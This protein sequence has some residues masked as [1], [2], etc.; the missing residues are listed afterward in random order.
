MPTGTGMDQLFVAPSFTA[1]ALMAAAVDEG[2]YADAGTTVLLT[3]GTA[4]IPELGGD[5]ATQPG[6]DGPARRFDRVV[7]LNE[8]IYPQHPSS[9]DP[10]T[11]DGRRQAVAAA[12]GLREP[13]GITLPSVSA[14]PSDALLRVFPEG[15]VDVVVDAA[16]GYGPPRPALPSQVMA[17]LRRLV[18]LD[19]AGGLRPALVREHALEH[20]VVPPAAFR[21]VVPDDA[22]RAVGQESADA[23]VLGQ[24]LSPLSPDEEQ[25]LH[26]AFLRVA[27]ALGHRRVVLAPPPS[28]PSASAHRLPALA[29]ELGLRLRVL[30]DPVP[31]EVLYAALRPAAAIGCCSTGLVTASEVYGMDAYAVGIDEVLERFGPDDRIGAALVGTRLP[32]VDVAPD[33]TLVRQAPL[34]VDL[35]LLAE[36]TARTDVTASRDRSAQAPAASPVPARTRLRRDVARA[37]RAASRRSRVVRRATAVAQAVVFHPR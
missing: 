10:D 37:V 26:E 3:V 29:E 24:D 28:G 32:R 8:A 5:L 23:I 34:D 20:A 33:G 2:L 30:D 16:A 1:A 6:F 25:R 11:D 9:W 36:E 35:P 7:S 22:G 17:R 14:A 21:A 12:V 13:F 4:P 27:A 18:S 31:A 19:L 15:P